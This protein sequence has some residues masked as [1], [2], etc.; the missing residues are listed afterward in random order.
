MSVKVWTRALVGSQESSDYWKNTFIDIKREPNVTFIVTVYLL[1][2]S[3]EIV[4]EE[5][6]QELLTQIFRKKRI[7]ESDGRQKQSKI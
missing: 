7:V 4:T 1:H 5:Q 6:R 2:D 3:V